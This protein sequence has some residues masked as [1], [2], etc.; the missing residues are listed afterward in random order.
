MFELAAV[1][2]GGGVKSAVLS[3]TEAPAM[4]YFHD[5]GY[6]MFDVLVFSC[7]EGVCKPEARIFEIA[8]ERLGCAAGRTVFVDDDA[9]YVAAAREAGLNAVVFESVEQVRAVLE[10]TP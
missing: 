5:M 10:E 6:T 4:A 7:A 2:E 1:L 3:N 9:R 8:V